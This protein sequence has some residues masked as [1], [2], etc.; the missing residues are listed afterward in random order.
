MINVIEKHTKAVLKAFQLQ[1]QRL[2]VFAPPGI[3]SLVKDGT[4]SFPPPR[5]HPLLIDSYPGDIYTLQTHLVADEMAL[6]TI[7]ARTGRI[8]L[9][10][11]GDLA[12]AGRGHQFIVISN[13]LNESP[14]MLLEALAKLRLNV[15]FLSFC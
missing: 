2:A 9:R 13:K 3:V 1:L 5:S 4:F 7:D 8:S 15:C 6:T 12:A 10:D 14:P 11:T